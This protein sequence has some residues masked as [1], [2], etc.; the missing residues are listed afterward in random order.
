MT[1]RKWMVFAIV[2]VALVG[3]VVVVPM[4][5]AQ[6]PM[7]GYGPGYSNGPMLENEPGP[8]SR[9]MGRGYAAGPMMGRGNGPGYVDEDG[10]GVCDRAGTGQGNGP[11]YV[12][13]DGDGVCDHAGT[14]QGNG[15]GYVDEDGD[16]VCDHAGAGRS[17][18]Q[19]RD[20]MAGRWTTN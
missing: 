3:A 13:E 8:G 6:G 9:M 19:M 12:D 5:F 15:P 14:G 1:A 18:R 7:N 16:G 4:A 2:T 17:G 10:D 11:G 20:R